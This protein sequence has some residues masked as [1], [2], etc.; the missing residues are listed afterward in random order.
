MLDNAHRCAPVRSVT[1]TVQRRRCTYTLVRSTRTL[2][3]ALTL[4][5]K[6][7]LGSHRAAPCPDDESRKRSREESARGEESGERCTVV[8]SLRRYVPDSF[9]ESRGRSTSAATAAGNLRD[10][11]SRR[12]VS[13]PS[14]FPLFNLRRFHR[15][16][17]PLPR[18]VY[19]F[20]R[21]LS[22]SLSL[23][24]LAVSGDGLLTYSFS[25]C[26]Y[27]LP[28][29][30][31]FPVSHGFYLSPS[32]WKPSSKSSYRPIPETRSSGF[33]I[34][35]VISHPRFTSLPLSLVRS[36]VVFYAA[37]KKTRC[38]LRLLAAADS[39]LLLSF[40]FSP[41]RLLRPI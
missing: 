8:M 34:T 30:Q 2:V 21:S 27:T 23:S 29:G 31:I 38:K 33:S 40:F 24:S 20:T 14:K 10:F 19:Y 9:N 16:C 25:F 1:K 5:W 4:A 17:S 37:E 12:R 11:E 3:H 6:R 15:V 36:L 22:L 26:T 28:G 13:L 35:G 18:A 7:L 41:R 32:R 39:F